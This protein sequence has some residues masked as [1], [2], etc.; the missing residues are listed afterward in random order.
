MSD[1]E[2]RIGDYLASH[3]GPF[4]ELQRRLGMLRENA[5]HA[6]RRAAIF[7]T[8]AWGV[9]L[10]LSLFEGR[11]F[12]PK[13]EHPFLLDFGSLARF[14]IAVGLFLLSETE[15]ENGLR[16]KMR[17]FVRAPILSPSSFEAAADAVA[18]ALK[19]RSSS[20]AEIV[21]LAIAIF[22]GFALWE[23]WHHAA[24]S[25]WAVQV[26]DAGAQI[27]FAGWWAIVFSAPIFYFLM[28][29]GLWRYIVWALLLWRIST[30]DLRLVASHP[31]GKGGLGFVAEYPNAYAMFVFGLSSAGAIV[32][33]RHVFDS[34][35]SSVTFG[36][37][38]SAW[39]AIVLVFF[40]FPLVAFTK[41]LGELKRKALEDLGAQATVF[42]RQAERALLGHN[43]VANDPAEA[44]PVPPIA[45][46]SGQ[47]A[48]S[49]KF[50]IF[51]LSRTSLAP[52]AAAAL[53]PFA[54]AGATKLP[55]KEVFAL[56]KKLLVI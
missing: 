40:G 47:Y 27:T 50:S 42:H 4:F 8:I 5:V 6:G 7:V 45:D 36:Y 32:V 48:I 43:L 39:L 49:R 11:T 44:A 12:G 34:G 31:D 18:T 2:S 15:V 21:C 13:D 46:P 20:A 23:Q 16:T 14:F 35:I 19:R 1:A 28:L 54:I 56:V 17:Q 52:I 55:Y 26:D 25:T 38:I 9:P 3:G 30:L 10:V 41:P 33:V 37:I 24:A 22:G 53:V 29:R 51:L